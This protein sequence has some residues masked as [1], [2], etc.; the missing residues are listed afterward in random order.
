[1][2]KRYEL[3]YIVEVIEQE[4][5]EAVVAKINNVITD[6]GGDIIKLD[7]WGKKKLAYEMRGKNDGLYVLVDFTIEPDVVRKELDHTLKATYEVLRHCI[8]MKGQLK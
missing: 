3:L 6:N 7:Q 8:W 1:M 2:K 5:Y 4:A